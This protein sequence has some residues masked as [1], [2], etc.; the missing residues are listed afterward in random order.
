[1]TDPM[2]TTKLSPM[3][4]NAAAVESDMLVAPYAAAAPPV[5]VVLT[6]DEDE[7]VLYHLNRGASNYVPQGAGSQRNSRHESLRLR[8]V[9]R[10]R[11]HQQEAVSAMSLSK[12]AIEAE[13]HSARKPE[14]RLSR[15]SLGDVGQSQGITSAQAAVLLAKYGPNEL[16]EN[17]KPRW[18]LFAE[19]FTG[20]MP[21]GIWMA[22]IIESSLQ[23]WLDAGILLAL[24]AI[25]GVVGFMEANKADNAVAALKVEISDAARYRGSSLKD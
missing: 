2:Q 11:H 17:T 24:Q 4:D 16:V 1:M 10:Q 12:A 6:N 20:P 9:R 8:D 15:I 5:E 18:K 25:N 3:A 22:I 14:H 19:Q 21:I 7:I 23:N 13:F